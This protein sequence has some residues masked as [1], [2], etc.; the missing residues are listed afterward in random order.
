VIL[1]PER[2]TPEAGA[3]PGNPGLYASLLD[4]A[5]RLLAEVAG[6]VTEADPAW[7]FQVLQVQVPAV[8]KAAGIALDPPM[9]SELESLA[10]YELG[11]RARY[12]VPEP[13]A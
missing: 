5:D 12:G 11:I 4:L 13:S 1:H 6:G 9:C 8:R 3:I 2:K 10:E 7:T